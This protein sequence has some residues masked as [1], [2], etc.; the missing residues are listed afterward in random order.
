MRQRI[1]Y[2]GRGSMRSSMSSPSLKSHT[3][4]WPTAT[5][6]Q[7]SCGGRRGFWYRIIVCKTSTVLALQVR[8]T[9]DLERNAGV[10]ETPRACATS[11][12]DT[13]HLS[14]VSIMS[15]WTLIHSLRARSCAVQS[16]HHLKTLN[17]R[18]HHSHRPLK[19]RMP[20]CP[21]TRAAN[22]GQERLPEDFTRQPPSQR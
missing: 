1:W 3:S 13:K 4:R 19:W 14:Q 21:G 11:A 16:L 18:C 12:A 20:L 8:S 10:Q 7:Y 5:A 15:V 22:M 6:A 9:F 17:A 2:I